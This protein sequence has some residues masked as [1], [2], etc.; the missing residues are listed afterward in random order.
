[1]LI[2]LVIVIVGYVAGKL[3]YMGGDFDRRL[4]NIIIDFTCPALILSSTMGGT[5]PDRR[6]IL[7]L[8]GISM[9]TY[10][11]LTAVAFG[12]PR[13]LTKKSEDHGPVGFALMF[14]NVGFIGY[15]IVGAIFGHQAIF[16]A[17]ILNVINTLTV[18]TIG[19]MLVN[20]GQRRML[21]QPKILISSPMIAAYLAIL[22]VALG[23]DNIPDIV[24][25]PVTMIGNITVPGALLIFGSSMSRLSWRTMLGSR[26]VYATTAFR[27]IILPLFL[28]AIFRVIGFDSLVVNINTL[29]IAMPVATY[30]TI[31]CLRYGRDT[32]LITEITFISTLLSVLTI[33]MVAQLLL[34]CVKM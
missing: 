28:Y 3:E 22:I 9:L 2:L 8:L 7:P 5:L 24:S 13:F 6:L 21:F 31:L 30:G 23:I 16:Y 19:V 20:G 18:F 26:V 15:P 34:G 14:G 12:L 10:L 27:L 25:Q 4:S 17:A 11:L 32:T 1:M 33:P 29:I